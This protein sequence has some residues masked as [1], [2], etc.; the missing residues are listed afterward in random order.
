[1]A[2]RR[3]PKSLEHLEFE[4]VA[5]IYHTREESLR[6]FHSNDNLRFLE[7]FA[8]LSNNEIDEKL[9][10]QLSEIEKDACLNLLAA[11]EAIFR[12]D[13]AIRCEGRD[14]AAISYRFREYYKE[15]AFSV[16]F[17]EVILE[18]WKG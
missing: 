4:T 12:L 11:I 17:E 18:E 5:E 14:K 9:K 13:Y 1:M 2:R 7:F 16:S 15:S 3:L 10:F 8:M 6:L